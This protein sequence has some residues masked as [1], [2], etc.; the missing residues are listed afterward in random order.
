[1]LLL[2]LYRGFIVQEED[3]EKKIRKR[4]RERDREREKREKE[5]GRSPVPNKTDPLFI[6]I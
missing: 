5:M 4:E 3:R 2:L 6:F 1:V